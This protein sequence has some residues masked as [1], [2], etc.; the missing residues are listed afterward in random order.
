M[1]HKKKNKPDFNRPEGRSFTLCILTCFVLLYMYYEIV[2]GYL[3]GGEDAPSL[4]LMVVGFLI[5]V[6]GGIWAGIQAI[7]LYKACCVPLQTEVEEELA[8]EEPEDEES[9]NEEA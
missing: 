5:L 7:R 8:P 1:N 3:A 4:L 2:V 9:E 6:G